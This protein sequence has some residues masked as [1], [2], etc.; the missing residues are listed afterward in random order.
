MNLNTSEIA[1]MSDD[2]L[3]QRIETLICSER[4]TLTS[5]LHHLR[6]AEPRRLFPKF[7]YS[8]LFEYATRRFGY[9][10]DQAYR[11]ISAMRLL[12]ELPELETKI[13]TGALSLTNLAQAQSLFRHEAKIGEKRSPE[14]KAREPGSSS[15]TYAT[16]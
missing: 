15:E 5:I 4:E 10:E 12:R 7:G 13:A 2:S 14:R 3:D 16:P 11:R 8:S 6:E 9:S 1:K